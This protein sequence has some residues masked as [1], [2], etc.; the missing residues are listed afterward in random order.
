VVTGQ[1]GFDGEQAGLA[2]IKLV[3]SESLPRASV[4][5]SLPARSITKI[6][7]IENTP[8]A[9]ENAPSKALP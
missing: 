9:R 7:G 2:P 5:Y 1:F 8:Q 3:L 6:A 4:E